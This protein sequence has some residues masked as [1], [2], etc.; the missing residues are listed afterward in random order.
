[1]AKISLAAKIA[2]VA[3]LAYEFTGLTVQKT[4]EGDN[5]AI[6]QLSAPIEH[7]R[8]SQEVEFNG[9]R[10][11][12]EATD[13]TEIKV[14]E[15]D[16]N[17]DFKWDTDTDTGSY[18]GSELILD[19][20]KSGQVWLRKQSFAAAGQEMRNTNRNQ[21]LEKLFAPKVKTPAAVTPVEN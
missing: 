3:N 16:F 13:V 9:K 4:R 19:V 17:E 2:L 20:S 7:V 1:M 18:E 5:V 15:N 21:R 14:H 8:G 10:V 12:I 6:L 11:A